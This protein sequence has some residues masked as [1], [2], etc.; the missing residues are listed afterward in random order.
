MSNVIT[1]TITGAVYIGLIIL[2]LLFHPFFLGL[3]TVVINY[4][5][6]REF[7][8]ITA[9]YGAK[10]PKDWIIYNVFFFFV[11]VVIIDFDFHPVYVLIPMLA[12]PATYMVAA[13]Y[14]KKN[15]TLNHLAFAMFGTI[16]ITAPLLILNLIQQ[17][18]KHQ[19]ISF[20]LA[21]FV[22][23]WTND[24]FAYLS[25]IAF[26]K[27]KMFE[28]ISPK[29]SWEGFAGGLMMGL[30]ASFIFYYFFPAPGLV[31]WLLFGTFTVVLSNFGDF[32]ESLLKRKA[33][34]KDSGSLLPGHGGVLD[35]IDSM[36]FV[37]PVIY[38]YLLIILK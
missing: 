17:Y 27:H 23:I 32:F 37:G 30:I 19:M 5:A 2:S 31:N 9:K 35:R 26:G 29:K 3:L 20:T 18:S 34:I 7:Q 1:R 28:R 38:M 13:L 4:F 6:L 14:D 25:G 12:L 33:G 15:D 24:T 36:L 21:M 10:V 22:I 11:S 16:Y 8:E